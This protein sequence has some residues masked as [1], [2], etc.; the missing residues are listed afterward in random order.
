VASVGHAL[1]L[2]ESHDP[3]RW[4]NAL[5]HNGLMPCAQHIL[6]KRCD[7]KETLAQHNVHC[8]H[9][10]HHPHHTMMV[11]C[12]DTLQHQHLQ[13]AWNSLARYRSSSITHSHLAIMRFR[14]TSG[15]L[16]SAAA[17]QMA[18]AD[19]GRLR[20]PDYTSQQH[21]M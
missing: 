13:H 10:P 20:G 1:K 9:H 17:L 8:S 12:M 16:T 14:N 15:M 7:N 18:D 5:T 21:N 11:A 19:Y 4:H 3:P 2:S 6:N